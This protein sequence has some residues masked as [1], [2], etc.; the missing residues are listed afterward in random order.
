M[1]KGQG[2]LPC[3]FYGLNWGNYLGGA[4]FRFIANNE[5]GGCG[6]ANGQKMFVVFGKGTDG[7]GAVLKSESLV[8]SGIPQNKEG[9]FFNGFLPKGKPKQFRTKALALKRGRHSQGS[10]VNAANFVPIVGI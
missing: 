3:P 7:E 5:R 8:K 10:Q 9:T 1:K 4:K 6:V 2:N